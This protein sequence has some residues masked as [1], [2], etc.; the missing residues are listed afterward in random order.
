MQPR[1]PDVSGAR[2]RLRADVVPGWIPGSDADDLPMPSTQSRLGHFKL[3]DPTATP[4]WLVTVV[5]ILTMII[6]LWIGDEDDFSSEEPTRIVHQDLQGSSPLLP[7]SPTSLRGCCGKPAEFR[8][9]FLDGDVGAT[10]GTP[11]RTRVIA[12]DAQGRQAR[13]AACEQL[14]VDLDLSSGHAHLSAATSPPRW[15]GAELSLDIESEVAGLVK[16]EVRIASPNPA[17]DVLLHTSE[18]RFS[19]GPVD[20]LDIYF[21]DSAPVDSLQDAPR[22]DKRAAW[23]P[24][25]NVVVTVV[26][27]DR[28]GNRLP[29]PDPV[30]KRSAER[31]PV[32]DKPAWLQEASAFDSSN[33]DLLREGLVLRAQAQGLV[34]EG[35]GSTLKID[36]QGRGYA[37]LRAK[38]RGVADVWLEHKANVTSRQRSDLRQRTVRTLHFDA[39]SPRSVA[40]KVSGGAS[41]SA[42]DAEWQPVAQDVKKAFLHAWHGYKKYAWGLDELQPLTKK[43]RDSF[44]G[45]GI[46]ILDSLSTLW[47]MGLQDE[48]DAAEEWVQTVLDFRKAN[49]DASFFELV[50]RALGGLLSAH[51]LS[52]RQIFLDRAS[53]LGE[54]LLVALQTP[55]KLPMPKVNLAQRRGVPSG[56]PTILAEAGSMQL[57]YRYLANATKKRHFRDEADAAF[58]AIQSA[59]I[60]G[61]MPV[62]LSPP[63]HANV[64]AMKSKFAVGALAD[65]YY[66]YLLK[67]WLQS[68]TE[69]GF[70]ELWIRVVEELPSLVVPDLVVPHPPTPL[71]SK[72]LPS[73]KVL[74]GK[75]GSTVG[76]AYLWHQDHLSCF[77][78]GMLA[79]GLMTLP[80]SDFE[81]NDWLN[82][83]LWSMAEGVTK[84]CM[85]MWTQTR[86]GLAPECRNVSPKSPH[87]FKEVPDTCRHSFLRPETAE[88]LFYLYRFTG[89]DKYRRWGK[90]MFEAIAKHAKVGAGFASV[91]NVNAAPTEKLDEMQS[92]VMAETFKYLYLLFSP[93]D[94]LDLDRYVLNTEG[95]P[96]PRGTL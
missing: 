42:A 76:Q 26:L 58:A 52:G 11:F 16:A 45:V 84:S 57:E 85:E 5:F 55:S 60:D 22:K 95:H 87:P 59:G 93:A 30:P 18:I 65:S 1:I 73:Y 67:Q 7:L 88:S 89:D 32:K 9:V 37:T 40:G 36:S 13:P 8:W 80:P 78:P 29:L 74:E 34:L 43:G 49:K 39:E 14:R 44:A 63:E 2:Q 71:Q 68:P 23:P 92:F 15:Y 31:K 20:T 19:S 28:F 6:S 27:Q 21:L 4:T 46:T 69:T 17:A 72:D 70:K 90:Q 62:Y 54:R 51:A 48:F 56:E 33:T 12:V 3:A 86:S 83:S 25:S 24:G 61:I 96:L 10:V 64:K 35:L 41:M 50:I 53:D 75:P 47:L 81:E 94:V 38:G 91:R 79:L 77:V 66:E 82:V